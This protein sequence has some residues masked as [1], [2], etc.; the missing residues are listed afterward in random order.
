MSKQY[1]WGGDRSGAALHYHVAA[2]NVLFI[3]E[4][5]WYVPEAQKFRFSCSMHWIQNCML[6][7][8]APAPAKSASNG[9][10]MFLN[11]GGLSY[12]RLR[13]PP[14]LAARSGIPTYELF[15]RCLGSS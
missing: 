5:E 6:T 12:L 11:I 3:G 8:L 15:D 10:S 9:P 14:Y 13:T 4:K 2:F 1:F 7:T